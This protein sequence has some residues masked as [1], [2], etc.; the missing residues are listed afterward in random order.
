M[1]QKTATILEKVEAL[2]RR[3]HVPS[4]AIQ[5]SVESSIELFFDGNFFRDVTSIFPENYSTPLF[6]LTK[7]PHKTVHAKSIASCPQILCE[8][9]HSG[10]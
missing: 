3:H 9:T 8:N 5:A 10:S 4:I 1:V 2:Y 7:H 6:A